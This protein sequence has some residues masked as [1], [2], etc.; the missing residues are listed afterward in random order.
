VINGL[1]LED[2]LVGWQRAGERKRSGL[3]DEGEELKEE[4][5]QEAVAAKMSLAGCPGLCSPEI[6]RDSIAQNSAAFF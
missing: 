5:R 3:E 1:R 2:L 6:L 4:R